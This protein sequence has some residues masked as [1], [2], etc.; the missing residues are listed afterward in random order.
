MVEA[1]AR[2]P[3]RSAKQRLHDAREISEAVAHQEEPDNDHTN[4][5]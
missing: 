3:V 2:S 4:K 1:E 5:Q